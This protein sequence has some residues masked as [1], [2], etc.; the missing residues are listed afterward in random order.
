MAEAEIEQLRLERRKAKA[1]FTREVKAVRQLMGRN[2]SIEEISEAFTKMDIAYEVLVKKHDSYTMTVKDDDKFEQE[3]AW[4][5]IC[6]ETFLNMKMQIKDYENKPDHVIVDAQKQDITSGDKN[7]VST[8]FVNV[9]RL[10]QLQS[11]T[12]TSDLNLEDTCDK[13]KQTNKNSICDPNSTAIPT[14]FSRSPAHEEMEIEDN[15]Y[16]GS[17]FE[18]RAGTIRQVNDTSESELPVNSKHF[19]MSPVPE[20]KEIADQ[21]ICSNSE[22]TASTSTRGN[23]ISKS[24]P[25][26]VTVNSQ[27][28]P[29]SS[30]PINGE[31]ENL[32]EFDNTNSQHEMTAGASSLSSHSRA[33]LV[34]K[35]T[36]DDMSRNNAQKSVGGFNKISKPVSLKRPLSASPERQKCCKKKCL[37]NIKNICQECQNFTKEQKKNY[38]KENVKIHRN[39]TAKTDRERNRG[40]YRI[41]HLSDGTTVCKTAFCKVLGGV[42]SDFIDKNIDRT[43]TENTPMSHTAQCKHRCSMTTEAQTQCT[44]LQDA[45]PKTETRNLHAAKSHNIKKPVQESQNASERT[46]LVQNHIYKTEIKRNDQSDLPTQKSK[47]PNSEYVLANSGSAMR[48]TNSDRSTFRSPTSNGGHPLPSSSISMH[49]SSQMQ[50]VAKTSEQNI[51]SNRKN[52]SVDHPSSALKNPCQPQEKVEISQ[53]H[54]PL[55]DEKREKYTKEM[56]P[57]FTNYTVDTTRCEVIPPEDSQTYAPIKSGRNNSVSLHG[58][59]SDEENRPAKDYGLRRYSLLSKKVQPCCKKRCLE[60]V[61]QDT[62]N[63]C[64][65]LSKKEKIDY[66]EKYV[67]CFPNKERHKYALHNNRIVCKTA[68]CKI[69]GVSY[70]FIL[71]NIRTRTKDTAEVQTHHSD[72]NKTETEAENTVSVEVKTQSPVTKTQTI[73]EPVVYQYD[74]NDSH[75]MSKDE[76]S[77]TLEQMSLVS[78]SDNKTETKH[79]KKSLSDLQTIQSKTKESPIPTE[80]KTSENVIQNEQNITDASVKP[81]DSDVYDIQKPNNSDFSISTHVLNGDNHSYS[82]AKTLLSDNISTQAPPKGLCS[83][84]SE[85]STQEKYSATHESSINPPKSSMSPNFS[86]SLGLRLV[87]SVSDAPESDFSTFGSSLKGSESIDPNDTINAESGNVTFDD[88][89]Q[90]KTPSLFNSSNML[91]ANTSLPVPLC[92]A[93]SSGTIAGQTEEPVPL[94]VFVSDQNINSVQIH[95]N[96]QVK[97]FSLFCKSI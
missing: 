7:N 82:M 27:E 18:D 47:S 31:A 85:T 22:V 51:E 11:N 58:H 74:Q 86:K 91:P 56:D 77:K 9:S 20:E 49:S 16:S 10:T 83:F 68:F 88:K 32:D 65:N 35:Q 48:Q 39:K 87:N 38:V 93:A 12:P 36:N 61:S 96:N 44:D 76:T 46:Y 15:N 8:S 24:N 43:Q 45:G 95:N 26:S 71:K 54:S 75:N 81:S 59:L 73:S 94:P 3:E 70:N 97:T 6:Q 42:C 33:S 64:Q 63:Y 40:F 4:L 89:S 90:S 62:K 30:N 66:V 84:Q 25:H 37:Q 2:R 79:D 13:P 52:D 5:K 92:E 67:N 55:N 28:I 69:L 72:F 53:K 1:H 19:S 50:N 60:D 78:S 29:I 14:Q 17:Q 34:V 21:N 23:D 57:S 80:N 41:Y